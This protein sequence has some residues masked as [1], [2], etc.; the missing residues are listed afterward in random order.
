MKK[1]LEIYKG[2]DGVSQ[3]VDVGGGLG[4]NLKLIVSKYPQI[5]ANFHLPLVVKD[6]PNFPSVEHIGGDM[7]AKIPHEKVVWQSDI[8]GIYSART[9]HD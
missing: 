7:F 6:A 9:A 4:T 1:V 5:K 3:V 8:I 2:F